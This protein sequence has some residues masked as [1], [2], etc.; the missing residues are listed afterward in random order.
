MSQSNAARVT[1]RPAARPTGRAAAAPPRLRVV[2]AGH[3]RTR[4]RLVLLCVALLTGGLVLLLMLNISLSRGAYELYRGQA[5]LSRLEEQRQ[6]TEEDL[7]AQQ[8]PQELAARARRLGMVPAPNVAFVRLDDGRVLGT[9]TAAP[10]PTHAPAPAPTAPPTASPGA[11]PAKA[12]AK[13]GA[14][15][16]PS[17][18]PTH[19]PV[20]P[21]PAQTDPAGRNP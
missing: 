14:T 16:R 8:A 15:A 7:L 19:A 17:H 21:V 5:Q 1:A 20:K 18:P 12:T 6:A 2:P 9:P 13:P 4:V 3:A 11:S 10:R